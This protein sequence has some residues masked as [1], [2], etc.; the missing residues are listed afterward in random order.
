M[1]GANT[2]C[3]TALQ[4][5]LQRVVDELELTQQDR[6]EKVALGRDVEARLQSSQA[7][8]GCINKQLAALQQQ[9]QEAMGQAGYYK[10]ER[11]AFKLERDALR[12]QLLSPGSLTPAAPAPTTPTQPA[13]ATQQASS[14]KPAKLP[15]PPVFTGDA[16]TDEISLDVWKIKMSDKM[17]QEGIRYPDALAQLRYVFSRVGGAAQAQLEPYAEENYARALRLANEHPSDSAFRSMFRILD[18]AFGDPDRANTAR[19][20]LAR[21]SQGK[22]TFAEHYAEFMRYAP[23]TGYDENSLLHMLR[24]QLS[25]E[26]GTALSYQATEPTTMD[27]LVRLC[28]SLDNRQR[29]EQHRQRSRTAPLQRIGNAAGSNPR[30]ASPPVAFGHPAS[31]PVASTATGTLP[32]PM[33]TSA[34]KLRAKWVTPEVL[35]ERRAKG[36]CVR[37][38]SRQHFVSQCMLLPAR[39]PQAAPAGAQVLGVPEDA[40]V[41][42]NEWQVEEITDSKWERRGHGQ[43][44]RKYLVK[45]RGYHR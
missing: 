1:E 26:L 21:L 11:D 8:L 31:P 17:G 25:Q 9:Y 3:M 29:A 38:G 39:R 18:N 10:A 40:E 35:A 16:R 43:P 13:A 41:E 28:Q 20:K 37:C 15:N 2:E 30:P 34:G 6:D 4:D 33:D 22:K 45:W 5:E 14:P 36:L 7:E 42:D 44:R 32:G 19:T 12:N 24:L 27:K 23:K